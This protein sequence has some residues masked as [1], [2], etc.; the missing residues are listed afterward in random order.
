VICVVVAKVN[1]LK[2]H[3]STEQESNREEGIELGAGSGN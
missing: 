2:Q 1:L 3:V